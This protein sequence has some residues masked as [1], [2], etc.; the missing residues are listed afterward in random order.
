MDGSR[1][2][3]VLI[4]CVHGSGRTG[5]FSA[6]YRMEYQGWPRWRA[7]AEEMM[8]GG[9]RSFAPGSA[10]ARFLWGYTPR[11]FGPAGGP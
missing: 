5:L 3:A 9:V 1:N 6:I 2:E 10:K 7:I 8:L 4:H 11:R